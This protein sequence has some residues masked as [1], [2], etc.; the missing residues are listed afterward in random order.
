[1][2]SGWKIEDKKKGMTSM[3]VCREYRNRY[4]Q[5]VGHA[6]TLD[7]DATGILPIGIGSALK[8]MQ[9]LLNGFS[10]VYVFT[11]QWG[12]HTDTY[13]LSGNVL[14]TNSIRNKNYINTLDLF[15]GKIKQVPPKF[16]A[17]RI[18][19]VHAY[20]L[21]RENKDFEIKERE[22][23]IYSLSI[24]DSCEDY[25]TFE[26][27]CSKGTY[28]RTLAVDIARSSGMIGAVKSIRRTKYGPFDESHCT[29]KIL[30]SEYILNFKIINLD[31]R[32][33]IDFTNGKSIEIL[34]YEL[35]KDELY[36]IMYNRMVLG[37]GIERNKSY[38]KPVKVFVKSDE[39]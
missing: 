24:L 31:I 14:S 21:A 38:I 22:I 32:Q 20:K 6:G 8:L 1:M 34:W 33:A 9:F 3:D 18:H 12:L 25:A 30:P 26:V 37:I 2:I 4:G 28:V 5:K 39:C 10:K 19:G 16:S 15:R 11:V 36:T 35:I 23:E 17:V 29:D 13:D 7:K 27:E